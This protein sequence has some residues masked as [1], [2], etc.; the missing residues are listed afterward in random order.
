[1]NFFRKSH[2]KAEEKRANN[3]RETATEFNEG[4][5]TADAMA[6]SNADAQNQDNPTENELHIPVNDPNFQILVREE[7]KKLRMREQILTPPHLARVQDALRLNETKMENIE[8][9]LRRTRSQL[10]R[11]HRY[12]ELSFE[13]HEQKKHLFEVNK[14]L[15]SAISDREALE[16]FEQFENVQGRFQRLTLLEAFRREQK[17]RMSELAHI[18]EETQKE[19][20]ENKKR[21]QEKR[22]EMLDARRKYEMGLDAVSEAQQVYGR[23]T[24]MAIDLDR[25]NDR[26]TTLNSMQ[27]AM[28]KE[29]T[30]YKRNMER[31]S[32][33]METLR[34]RRQSL[35]PHLRMAEHAELILEYLKRF[36]ELETELEKMERQVVES[37]R[38]QSDE[39]DMLGRVY[40]EYQQIIQDIQA[41]QDELAVHRDNNHGLDSYRLQERAMKLKLRR[42]MLLSAQS[43]WTRIVN[44]YNMIEDIVKRINSLRLK[45]ETLAANV[46]KLSKE[47]SSLRHLVRDKEYTFT[48]SKSQNVI[49][50]RSDLREGSSCTVCGA[51][52][53]PYHSD[54]ILEQNKLIGEIKAEYEALAGELKTKEQ[55]LHEAEMEES[56]VT[57]TKEETENTLITLRALQNGYVQDWKM[58][59]SLDASFSTCDSS[60]NM[61]ARTAMLRQLTENIVKEVDL[62]QKELD[63]FNFHQQRINILNDQI[64]VKEQKKNELITRLNEV[65]TGCQVMAGHLERLQNS[66]QLTRDNYSRLFEKLNKMIT[67]ADWRNIWNR[68]HETLL[69]RIQEM[70]KE[71]LELNDKLTEEEHKRALQENYLNYMQD[72]HQAIMSQINQLN[73]DKRL[74]QDRMVEDK[75]KMEKLTGKELPKNL[76]QQVINA[77]NQAREMY[78][79]QMAVMHDAELKYSETKGRLTENNDNGAIVDERSTN[80]RLGVDLWMRKYNATH[81]PVQYNEL[82]EMFANEHDWNEIRAKLREVQMDAMLTQARVD[83]IGSQLVS[84]QA[85]GGMNGTDTDVVQ[86][87]LSAQIE[88]LESKRRDTM[89]QI[90]MLSFQLNTHNKAENIIKNEKMQEKC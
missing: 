3:A 20:E 8:E 67:I 32:T 64:A 14:R 62:A 23:S 86:N 35:A 78:D 80:E 89:M 81:P 87:Q 72:S 12:S 76:L 26:L 19:L 33:N 28:D 4:K 22:E 74:C 55:Q 52:H 39:N 6:E 11:V 38:K 5:N 40:N 82:E 7:A 15:A 41:L 24:Y 25:I 49:Q 10:E 31:A 37:T 79:K 58:F 17:T 85:E 46:E 43:L 56:S 69:M 65:N 61:D 16:R 75:Q 50:L 60:V 88:T 47:V 2:N 42:E 63:T 13:L 1:M 51:T 18:A 45:K 21:M 90:A 54:T 27:Q 70:S 73:E 83:K 68:N 77:Y 66:K 9:N 48:L 71:C 84:L 29:I 57:A 59:S 53:H 44:G 30:E 36:G 34:T